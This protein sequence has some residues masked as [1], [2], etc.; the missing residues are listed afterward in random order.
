MQAALDVGAMS[1]LWCMFSKGLCMV[2]KSFGYYIYIRA[3]AI[4]RVSVC[5]MFGSV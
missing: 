1:G 4:G 5:S 3:G 2:T